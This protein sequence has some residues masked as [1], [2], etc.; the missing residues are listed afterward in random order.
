M[1]NIVYLVAYLYVLRE[2]I[3]T[4]VN[5]LCILLFKGKKKKQFIDKKNAHSFQLVHRSQKDPLQAD[6][7]SS[8]H[9]LVSLDDEAQVSKSLLY[10]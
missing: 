8:K 9:V 2:K 1:V 4:L 3:E 7:D 5:V 10:E 6:E